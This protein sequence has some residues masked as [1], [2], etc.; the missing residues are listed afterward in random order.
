[1]RVLDEMC[2][3]LEDEL[4]AVAKKAK[5]ES[6]SPTE[7][8]SVYKSVD[9]L[10]DIETIKAMKDHGGYS[11]NG[12]YG[13]YDDGYMGRYSGRDDRYSELRGRDSMGRYTSRDAGYSR[14][15]EADMLRDEIR[16][17]SRKLDRM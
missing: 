13:S 10:K 6:I 2:E 1:M 12:S 16:N 5:K 9:I 11:N 15:Y 7:L 3:I 4:E 17:M 14:D 8:E